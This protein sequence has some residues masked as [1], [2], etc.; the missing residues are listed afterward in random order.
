MIECE[1]CKEWFHGKCLKLNKNIADNLNNFYCLSCSL[2]R[3]LL[4]VNTY[5]NEFYNEK[6]I[7]DID[8]N[9]FINDG[10]KYN[11]WQME[12]LKNIQSKVNEWKEK[13]KNLINELYVFFYV[14]KNDFLDNEYE[15]RINILFLESEGLCC[16]INLSFKLILLLKISDWFKEIL[17]VLKNKKC[18]E[19]EKKKLINSSYYIF[20]GN[21]L[22]EKYEFEEENKLFKF[23]YEK[24][25][26]FIFNFSNINGLSS[27]D[28]KDKK[29]VNNMNNKKKKIEE[30]FENLF[31][32]LPVNLN[33]SDKNNLLNTYFE[34]KQM[35]KMNLLNNDY[36]ILE[37]TMNKVKQFPFVTETILNVKNI[38][39]D[40]IE[41]NNL[42]IYLQKIFGE[43]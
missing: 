33:E 19:K 23:L 11:F 27:N 41:N 38:L 24:G 9:E 1:C 30:S 35:I 20:I 39:N 2:R 43:K 7:S 10:E 36:E 26:N 13:Y 14:N 37:S 12:I 18:S 21:N 17:R 3:D 6:R 34:W 42:K 28:K 32:L 22:L 25:A 5:H 4:Q 15:K 16:E 29:N 40:G 31:N 8:L